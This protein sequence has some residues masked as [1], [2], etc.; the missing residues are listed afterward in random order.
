MRRSVSG[1]ARALA[2]LGS[3]ALAS[4]LAGGLIA[5]FVVPVA[6][7]T[8][9]LAQGGVSYFDSLP[10]TVVAPVLPEKSTMYYSDGK[11]VMANFFVENRVIVPLSQIAPVMRQAIVAIEDSRFYTEGGVDPKGVLRAAVNNAL[12][13]QVQGASTLT[14]QYIKNLNVERAYAAGDTAAEQQATARSMSR[15]LQE[16]RQAIELAKIQTKDQILS[17]YLNI[18][19]FGDSTYGIEAAAEYYFSVHASQLSL[20]QAATLAGM[21]QAP[22]L[23]DPFSPD[24][25][26]RARG[27]QR[28]NEVLN[29]MYQLGD[30]TQPQYQQAK[31]LPLVT[32]RNRPANG[33]ITAGSA[34]YFCDYV[35]HTIELDPGFA[36]LGKTAAERRDAITRG[37]LKIV[38]T[39]SPSMQQHAWAQVTAKVPVGDSSHVVAAADTVQPG[40]GRILAMT[41]ST[42]YDPNGKRGHT[43]LNY[44]VDKEYG[45]SLG[46]QTGS[47]FKAFTLA[48][49]LADGRSLSDQVDASADSMPFSDFT[50]CGHHLTGGTYS[51]GNS[52]PGVSGKMSVADA[53]ANSVNKAFVA[54]ETQLDL[55]DIADTATRLG[56]HLAAPQK[57]CASKPSQEVPWCVPSLTLGPANIAPLTMATAYAGFAANGTYCSPVSVLSLVD[58]S[59]KSVS[60]PQTQCRQA[61]GPDI[62]SGV[63]SAL[64]NVLTA[65]TAAGQALSGRDSAGKTGTTDASTDTW[66]VGYTTQLTTAVWVADP[67]VYPSLGGQRP[68]HDMTINGHFYGGEIFGATIAAPIWHNIMTDESQGM[69]SQSLP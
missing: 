33:C 56:V 5:G 10:S 12:G 54:M 43:E 3:F 31:T 20:V 15:K 8:G 11:T 23:Y 53:T 41:Q 63:T 58:R 69:D 64:R 28:R 4:V 42:L 67:T 46:F 59:G 52:E 14:E 35:L 34:A 9:Q 24:A 57:I 65:G 68:L 55:C 48:T 18:A 13:K 36:G 27:L 6:G 62:A 19:L 7:A 37:G 29:R 49:W 2:L 16:M 44:S 66:F 60:V 38:T 17:N 61:I 51:Y 1:L 45:G 32:H 40:T 21:V 25:K 50:A 39:L 30:I 26:A 22:S 47:T